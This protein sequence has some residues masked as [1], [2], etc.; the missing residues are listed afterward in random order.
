MEFEL[1]KAIAVLTRTPQVL[2]NLLLDLPQ[3][4]THRN[5]GPDTW[6]PFDIVGHLIHGEQTDWLPRTRIILG[7]AD[8]K[9]FVPFDRFAQFEQSKGKSLD[10]L[11]EEFERLR[12]ENLIQL[13][14]LNLSENDLNKQ[15]T[16]PELGPVKLKE[17]LAAWVTHD[18]GHIVQISRVMAKQYKDEV[19]PWTQYISILNQ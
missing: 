15:G 18:L 12:N 1:H 5:E 6:S 8:D 2:H 10:A 19:G 14:A 17:L 11:L 9:T 4:W 7:D 16:H 13:K 3:E